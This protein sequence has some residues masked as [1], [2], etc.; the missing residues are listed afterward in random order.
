MDTINF[1]AW[2]PEKKEYTT[3][4]VPIIGRRAC[5]TVGLGL[6]PVPPLSPMPPKPA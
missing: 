3:D 4:F 5:G 2:D 1:R 6:P